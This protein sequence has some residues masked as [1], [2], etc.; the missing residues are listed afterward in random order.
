V[1]LE[2]VRQVVVT[3]V[4]QREWEAQGSVRISE[5]YS[6]RWSWCPSRICKNRKSESQVILPEKNRLLEPVSEVQVGSVREKDEG[7]CQG[8]C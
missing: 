8:V 7:E 3:V 2:Q 5:M 6:R 1:E 4:G